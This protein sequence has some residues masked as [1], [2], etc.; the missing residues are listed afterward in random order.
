M[1]N[2]N[3]REQM[4]RYVD[5]VSFAQYEATLFLDTHPCDQEALE[6]FQHYTKLRNK[7]LQE[8][9]EQFGPLTLDTV[10]AGCAKKWDWVA[11][12]FPWEIGG[13]C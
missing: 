1:R 5:V 8:F 2:G 6:Y 11:T 12:P 10:D 13:A 3:D 4:L 7:A 9:A